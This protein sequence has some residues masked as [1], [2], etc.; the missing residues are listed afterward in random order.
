[1]TNKMISVP[2]NV[3]QD[4]LDYGYIS[5]L[6]S[7]CN[8][9]QD[10]LRKALTYDIETVCLPL[11][12]VTSWVDANKYYTGP[13]LFEATTKML[14]AVKN[15]LPML[16]VP[17]LGVVYKNCAETPSPKKRVLQWHT[18]FKTWEYSG[19]SGANRDHF[20]QL[21][22]PDPTVEAN[23]ISPWRLISDPP[24]DYREVV[25]LCGGYNRL[26][27]ASFYCRNHD[28]THWF[29]YVKGE[30]APP[31]PEGVTK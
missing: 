6:N 25:W 31:L 2:A 26:I 4:Y 30:C 11:D 12:V 14:A 16:F 24:D 21:M 9:L 10:V 29:P 7:A 3:A 1:M 27:V 5:T 20:W 18:G 28:R 15:A 22:L 13:K 17:V 23:P 8:K 19:Y